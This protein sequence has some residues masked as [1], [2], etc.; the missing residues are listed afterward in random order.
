MM[1]A[2]ACLYNIKTNVLTYSNASHDFPIIM[3]PLTEAKKI[4]KNDL[5]FLSESRSKRLG[6]DPKAVYVNTSETLAPGSVL[7]AYT[8]GLIDAVNMEGTAFGERNMMK[9]AIDSINRGAS[10][11]LLDIF[12]N[13][14]SKFTED[15]E[16]PDDITFLGLYIKSE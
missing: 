6:D 10:K 5:N 15:K 2:F 1:T 8:D 16:Q 12:Q 4:K 3:P 14:I 13:Q 9:I 11:N 7:F